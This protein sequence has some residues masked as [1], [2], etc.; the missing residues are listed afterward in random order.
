MRAFAIALISLATIPCFAQY[1][2][3]PGCSPPARVVVPGYVQPG[4]STLRSAPLPA[5]AAVSVTVGRTRSGGSGTLVDRNDQYGLVVSCAHLFRDGNGEIV[6]RFP[7]G[8]SCGGKLLD[9]DTGSDLSAI[10]IYAPPIE[11]IAI[12]A[13]APQP[14]APVS[15]VGYGP[16][17]QVARR[18]SVLGYSSSGLNRGKDLIDITGEAISGDSG[19]PMLDARGQLCGVLFGARRGQTTGAHCVLVRE[20][21]ARWR[22]PA[23]SNVEG[24]PSPERQAAP[25]AAATMPPEWAER[26]RDVEA[27]Q[28]RLVKLVEAQHTAVNGRFDQLEAREVRGCDCDHS[29]LASQSALA[30]VKAR[31]EGLAAEIRQ[32]AHRQP[33]AGVDD[34][35]APP[36]AW[37]E[38]IKETVTGGVEKYVAKRFTFLLVGL[39]VPG[40]VA[41]VVVFLLMRRA[42][43][44]GQAIRE[45][46]ESDLQARSSTAR[47]KTVVV[48]SESPPPPQVVER[49]RA[50]V[51]VQVPTDRQTAIEWAM[52]E[53]V[54]R[55]PGA[56]PTVETIEAYAA[57]YQS[58]MK[59]KKE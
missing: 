47:G 15:F 37:A 17:S 24:E 41:A 13:R 58:G 49:E 19:G 25:P 6:V 55:N 18:G 48:H 26:V 11:P 22:L 56:R 23:R 51:E 59:P 42:H 36:A 14:G 16:G 39:G 8:T 4:P 9:L 21:L 28:A 20:F 44:G 5:V 50:F 43:R 27:E 38:R 1:C 2:T 40:W 35:S 57:Q 29:T 52:D 34:N 30:A 53:Y 46:V 45:R 31:V 7:D 3:G 33:T 12:A 54:K 32:A 10:L